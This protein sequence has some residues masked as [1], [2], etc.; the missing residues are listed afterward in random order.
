[1]TFDNRLAMLSVS[2]EDAYDKLIIATSLFES[3][4]SYLDGS[5]IWHYPRNE[6]NSRG[7][8]LLDLYQREVKEQLESMKEDIDQL[9][10]QRI[11]SS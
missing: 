7:L 4:M 3:G 10:K 1:M 11:S 8:Y 9:K 5:G 2:L 6:G